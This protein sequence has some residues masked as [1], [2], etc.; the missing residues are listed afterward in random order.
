[1][2]ATL[3]FL[4]LALAAIV[5]GCYRITTASR[6]SQTLFLNADGITLRRGDTEQSCEWQQ[7]TALRRTDETIQSGAMVSRLYVEFGDKT[8]LVLNDE[9]TIPH[10]GLQ[11][12][13]SKWHESVVGTSIPTSAGDLQS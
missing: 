10:M 5:F 1:M 11:A 6:R 12:R 2:L 13:M 8:P 9:W 7:V 4:I 3:V